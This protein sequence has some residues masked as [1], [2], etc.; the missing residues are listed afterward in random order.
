MGWEMYREVQSLFFSCFSWFFTSK[1][2]YAFPYSY[3]ITLYLNSFIF[4]LK[5]IVCVYDNLSFSPK[6]NSIVNLVYAVISS[7]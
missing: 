7:S 3:F 6:K 2:R 1:C 4:Y 5:L